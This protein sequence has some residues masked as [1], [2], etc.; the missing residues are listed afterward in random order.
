MTTKTRRSSAGT[1]GGRRPTGVPANRAPKTSRAA[2]RAGGAR[3]ARPKS[4]SGCSG[5]SPSTRCR[6]RTRSPRPGWRSGATRLFP[7]C[8]RLCDHRE[9]L[10]HDLKTKVGDPAMTIELVDRKIGF[11]EDGSRPPSRRP[12]R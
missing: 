8:R 2:T 6:T 5:A 10:I 7:A 3:A 12:T 11:L 1:E 9:A 4:Y